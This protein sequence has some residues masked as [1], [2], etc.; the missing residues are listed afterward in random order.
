MPLIKENDLPEQQDIEW[1]S[2]WRDEWLEWISGFANAQGGR[3]YVGK[4]DT[5]QAVGL[6]DA[7]RQL[8]EL[9]DKIK[10]VLGIVLDVNLLQEDGGD[11]IEIVVPAL[12]MPIACKGS[13]YYRSGA[14]NKRLSGPDLENFLLAKR[15]RTWDETPAPDVKLKDLDP[16]RIQMLKEYGIRSKRLDESVKECGDELFLQKLRLIDNDILSTAAVLLFHP[17]PEERILGSYVKIGYFTSDSEILYQDVV[18]GPLIEQADKVISLLYSK[19]LKAAISYDG[20][21]RVEDFPFPEAATREIVLN[22]ITNKHY[23]K[24]IPIQIRVYDD[25]L[26]VTNVGHLPDGW[27]VE[28]LFEGNAAKPFKH[29][30]AKV[31]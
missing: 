30:L 8:K 18:G 16:A 27:T 21:R 12:P 14:T 15:G 23:N 9:P 13:Y 20:I 25:R 3:L 7:S 1:K 29:L 11:I 4:T 24:G 10:S 6:A 17:N 26:V 19:Y 22:A 5:G 28:S 31:F 2:T